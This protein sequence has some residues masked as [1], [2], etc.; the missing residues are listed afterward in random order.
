MSIINLIDS[1][2]NK[3]VQF[4]SFKVGT[5]TLDC[6]L[7]EAHESNLIVTESPMESGALIADHSYLEPKTYSVR[8]I[9]VSYEPF[10]IVQ[11]FLP[12]NITSLHDLPIPVGIKAI[13]DYAIGTINRYAATAIQTISKVRTV[14]NRFQKYL[15]DSLKA[16]GDISK[17]TDRASELYEELL[18]MQASEDFHDVDTAVRSY[19]NMV[20]QNINGVK[21]T[22]DGIEV[23]LTFKEVFIVNTQT[24]TG[25]SVNLPAKQVAAPKAVETKVDGQKK[26]GRA[27]AQASKTSSKGNTQPVKQSES[28]KKSALNKMF[29]GS[30][31]GGGRR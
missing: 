3:Q 8:G 19:T 25:L 20:L 29:G 5:F 11:S 23:A 27:A 26:T 9:I 12:S 22:D 24:V 13:S 14:A 2:T 28:S 6:Q 1:S 17:V 7:E 4:S 21:G 30:L 31:G 18:T 16:L 10:N 15:P